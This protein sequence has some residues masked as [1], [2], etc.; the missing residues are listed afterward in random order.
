MPLRLNNLDGGPVRVGNKL[1]PEE[2]SEAPLGDSTDWWGEG[3]IKDVRR[4]ITGVKVAGY[5]ANAGEVV[6]VD[7]S[8]GLV[9]ITLPL[10]ASYPGATI[11]LK[12]TT[13]DSN[14]MQAAR[15][16]SDTVE[17]ATSVNHTGSREYATY[18]SD[19]VSDWMRAA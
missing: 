16:G 9:A 15:S 4:V 12:K 13:T 19:G 8:G 10:A 7:T 1:G 2:G 3:Y 14:S 17:G 11:T 5:T 18:I 6:R